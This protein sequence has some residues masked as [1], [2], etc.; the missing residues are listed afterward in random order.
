MT[1]FAPCTRLI[2]DTHTS[3]IRR[4]TVIRG[5]IDF[6]G[7]RTFFKLDYLD[8]HGISKPLT[9]KSVP[10]ERSGGDL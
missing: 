8:N 2:S 10:F 9:T 5:G 3:G 6:T 4:G 7:V 1:L